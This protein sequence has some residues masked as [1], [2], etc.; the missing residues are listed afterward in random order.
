[1]RR[2]AALASLLLA[3]VLTVV[4][5]VPAGAAE[6]CSS[7]TLVSPV[8]SRARWCGV[9]PGTGTLRMMRR[10]GGAEEYREVPLDTYREVIR[11]GNVARYVAEEI[12]PRFARGAA[13]PQ[14]VGASAPVVA[15]APVLRPRP[16]LQVTAVPSPAIS[17]PAA[18]PAALRPAVPEAVAPR[19]A[20][21][22]GAAAERAAVPVLRPAAQ[23]VR[24]R[25][26]PA[27][28]PAP[29]CAARA[30]GE[31]GAARSCRG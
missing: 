22:R 10:A 15:A 6:T 29:V 19:P 3:P 14:A 26:V 21:A 13:V 24:L 17:S 1:M 8:F 11:T 25:T 5:A 30:R 31:A 18:R 20:A 4:A 28:V 12:G 23:P 16:A 9:P 27:P 2:V 7:S